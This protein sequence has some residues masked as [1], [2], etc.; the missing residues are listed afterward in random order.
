MTNPCA[1]SSLASDTTVPADDA[2]AL[3]SS[4]AKNDPKIPVP[5]GMEIG[6][7]KGSTPKPSTRAVEKS[8][9]AATVY[10]SPKKGLGG[11][12]PNRKKTAVKRKSK[13]PAHNTPETGPKPEKVTPDSATQRAV[14]ASLHRAPTVDTTEKA[15][16]DDHH[17]A[18]PPKTSD[19]EDCHDDAES[20]HEEAPVH[21]DDNGPTS[22]QVRARL[23]AKARYMRFSRSMKS[24]LAAC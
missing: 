8:P 3:A 20:Y 4:H 5:E 2:I 6:N 24:S 12:V 9:T 1:G 10:Y 16:K 22:E 13:K 15:N 14:K 23:A 21:P 18:D 7:V 17:D 19:D 11:K